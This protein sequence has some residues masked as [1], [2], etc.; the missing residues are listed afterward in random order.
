MLVAAGVL[1]AARRTGRPAVAVAAVALAVVVEVGWAWHKTPQLFRGDAA[2]RIDARAE[3]AAWIALTQR[4]RDVLLG[5]EPLYLLAWERAGRRPATVVPRADGKLAFR[6]LESAPRPLGR[7]VFVLDAGDSTNLHPRPT[8][9]LRLP[10]PARR[11]DARVFGPY[12]VIRTR[13]ATRSTAAFLDAAHRAM[14]LGDTLEIGDAPL[15]LEAIDVAR[16][17]L[18]AQRERVASAARSVSTNSR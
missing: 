13:R 12:L 11:F 1:A 3:A 18:V 14:E 15:N 5:Y 4:P 2:T 7:G 10:R 9:P 6:A 17:E 8:I 16:R